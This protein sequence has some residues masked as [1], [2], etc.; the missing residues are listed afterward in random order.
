MSMRHHSGQN[1]DSRGA[2]EWVSCPV[3]GVVA[4][5]GGGKPALLL[6]PPYF[7]WKKKKW[8]K[9][10][11][12]TGEVKHNRA[13]TLPQGLD[14]PLLPVSFQSWRAARMPLNQLMCKGDYQMTLLQLHVHDLRREIL[15]TTLTEPGNEIFFHKWMHGIVVRL[16]AG[17]GALSISTTVFEVMDQG[18]SASPRKPSR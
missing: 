18:T 2:A 3:A 10:E 6:D 16:A 14:S 7:G 11:K 13:T 15:G 17:Q 4:G 5:G 9:E 1:V 8:H 12:P